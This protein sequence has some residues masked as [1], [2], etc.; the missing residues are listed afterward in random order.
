MIAITS[1]RGTVPRR[2]PGCFLFMLIYFIFLGLVACLLRF[3]WS[4]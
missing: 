3:L 2:K 4:I 1:K